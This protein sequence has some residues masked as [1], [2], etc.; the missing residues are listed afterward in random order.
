MKCIIY[1]LQ[2]FTA[3]AKYQSQVNR[4][5]SLHCIVCER[6]ISESKA[7]VAIKHILNVVFQ[8]FVMAV[9]RERRRDLHNEWCFHTSRRR[10]KQ[11][12]CWVQKTRWGRKKKEHLNLQLLSVWGGQNIHNTEKISIRIRPWPSHTW[13]LIVCH[14]LH[15]W[16]GCILLK[17]LMRPSHIFNFILSKKGCDRAFT[18]TLVFWDQNAVSLKD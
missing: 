13:E 11:S 15:C 18:I 12:S 1:K 8:V 5:H 6:R 4:P 3:W 14:S 9:Q 7:S 17:I 10:P 2:N 16:T